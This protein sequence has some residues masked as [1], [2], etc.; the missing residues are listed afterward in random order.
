[1]PR[2]VWV[3]LVSST[4]LGCGPVGTLDGARGFDVAETY[5]VPCE[6][7]HGEILA[8]GG[9]VSGEQCDGG[10]GYEDLCDFRTSLVESD[11]TACNNMPRF[12]IYGADDISFTLDGFSSMDDLDGGRANFVYHYR[13]SEQ[14]A[15]ALEDPVDLYAL[16][17]EELVGTVALKSQVGNR[18]EME[19]RVEELFGTLEFRLCD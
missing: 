13:C 11:P 12:N 14:Q 16:E 18:V 3:V 5:L 6:T 19:F 17:P 2:L 9:A 10:Q 4:V 7:S 8:Q 15:D 1:M